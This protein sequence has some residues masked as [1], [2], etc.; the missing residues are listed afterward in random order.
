MGQAIVDLMIVRYLA[1]VVV[2]ALC[3]ALID[4]F[5]GTDGVKDY[6]IVFAG[7]CAFALLSGTFAFLSCEWSK[8]R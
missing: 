7:S 3:G 2:F 5:S 1:Q 4:W 6:R 8:G